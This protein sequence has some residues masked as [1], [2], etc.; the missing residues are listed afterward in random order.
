MK[1]VIVTYACQISYTCTQFNYFS[2]VGFLFRLYAKQVN[3]STLLGLRRFRFLVAMLP[4]MLNILSEATDVGLT[5]RYRRATLCSIGNC[6]PLSD[7]HSFI[8]SPGEIRLLAFC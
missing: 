8:G 1:S 5:V 7:H 4:A 3:M 6:L 2:I